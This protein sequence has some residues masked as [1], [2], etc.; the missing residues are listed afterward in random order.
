[1]DLDMDQQQLP[2]VPA[3]RHYKDFVPEYE[4][5]VAVATFTPT[6]TTTPA[7]PPLAAALFRITCRNPSPATYYGTNTYLLVCPPALLVIDPGPLD[8][9]SHVENNAHLQALMSFIRDQTLSAAAQEREIPVELVAILVTHT[10]SD[11]SPLA[12]PLKQKIERDLHLPA[13]IFGFGEHPS[14]PHTGT[15]V[16]E[17]PEQDDDRRSADVLFRP[18][19]RVHDGQLIELPL[20]DSC[21]VC[22]PPLSIACI[23]TPGHIA[24]HIVFVVQAHTAD[25]LYFCGDHVMGWSTTVVAPPLGNMTDYLQSLEKLLL[26]PYLGQAPGTLYPTHG[27]PIPSEEA[28][29]YVRSLHQHRLA[30]E[31]QVKFCL[32]QGICALDEMVALLYGDKPKS[33][34]PLAKLSL[35]C[36]VQRLYDATTSVVRKESDK[37]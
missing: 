37:A 9:R 12:L 35:Q 31:A 14:A 5:P 3:L 34:W 22:R 29:E 21:R 15:A 2:A 8:S 32:D 23:H 28:A 24:N 16:A 18:D 19:I 33:V 11:H 36:H 25:K 10:H 13:V 30:R 1:M 7:V 4:T 17:D 6:T 26:C 27:P 20:A